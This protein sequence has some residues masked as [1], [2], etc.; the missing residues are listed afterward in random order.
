[1]SVGDQLAGQCWIPREAD[2]VF[3]FGPERSINQRWSDIIGIGPDEAEGEQL[4][5]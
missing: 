5:L 4:F 2:H 3:K 1:M